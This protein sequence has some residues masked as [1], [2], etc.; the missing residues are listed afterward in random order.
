[1][2]IV[3]VCKIEHTVPVGGKDIATEKKCTLLV[4]KDMSRC[5]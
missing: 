1:M 5:T 4:F 2:W 3:Q